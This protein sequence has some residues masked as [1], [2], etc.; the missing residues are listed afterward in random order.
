MFALAVRESNY[1]NL[2]LIKITFQELRQPKCHGAAAT[3]EGPASPAAT[4]ALVALYQP[5]AGGERRLQ[6]FGANV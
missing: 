2:N 5:G 3:F 6:V 4:L 1:F